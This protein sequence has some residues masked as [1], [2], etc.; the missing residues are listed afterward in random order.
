MHHLT[1]YYMAKRGKKYEQALKK[2]EGVTAVSLDEAIKLLKETSVTKFDSSCEIH[3][4]LGVDPTHAD[5]M[6]R[7]T[8]ALPHGT[9]KTVR[10]IAFVAEDKVKEATAAG[11]VKAGMD[12]LIEEI[13]KGFLDFDVAVATPDAMKSLSKVAKILGTKGL[14]PNP[15]AGTVTMDIE[16][17]IAEIKKGRVEYRTDKLGQIHQVFGKVSF[18]ED[19]LKDNLKTFIKA[20]VD[21][22]PSTV[23]GTY[24]QNISLATTMGP[25]VKLDMASAMTELK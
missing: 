15:K 9:G 12:E 22:K 11:A 2:L 17:T 7:S 25:G 5:Q 13:V 21:S 24:I 18:T 20:V 3:M 23:K 10:V 1:Q 19:Q 8:I 14:M 6:V 4:K 16:K